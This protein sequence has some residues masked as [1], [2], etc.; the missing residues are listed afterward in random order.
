MLKPGS[1]RVVEIT[2]PTGYKKAE[3]PVAVF[4]VDENGRIIRK[5]K[6]NK[7]VGGTG[8]NTSNNEEEHGI[9][10]IEIV[11]KKEQKIS[12]V[13]VD[14]ANKET[15][16]E[17]AA[18]KVF[19]KKEKTGEYSDTELKL[20]EKTADGK[21][22]RLVL[23]DGVKAPEGYK[24]VDKFTTGKDGKI[25]FAFQENGYYALKE[26]KAPSGYL[27]PKGYVK[28]FVVKDGKVQTDQ[29]KTEMDVRKTKSADYTNNQINDVYLTDIKMK[30]NSAHEKITY[31]KDKST[32]T[33]SGLPY[34]NDFKAKNNLSSDGITISA[35]LVNNNNRSS[36]TKIYTLKS[37]DYTNNEGKITIN[38]YELV[39]ELEKKTGDSFESE[40]TIELSMYST[41]ALSTEL[42]IKSNIEIGDGEDKI[43]ED[44][45]FHI[46]TK[47]DE[48]VDHS[49]KFTTSEEIS[50]D[51]TTNAYN[52]IQIENKNEAYQ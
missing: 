35:K 34:D 11:N 25:E 41:L 32:I 52:P 33:L 5:D 28:E 15:K 19:Y 12:F 2:A 4:D 13:K 38:L 44:R 39:K 22:E 42:D 50:K 20:Y 17:G 45:T 36:D 10:P 23:K 21:T 40:N 7:P 8:G 14:A 6:N 43:S 18:F 30:F 46:G 47:G 27:T 51:K 3:D 31:E 29:Y 9:T 1:Y 49:Y 48:K 26:T 24:A 16:L 37:T